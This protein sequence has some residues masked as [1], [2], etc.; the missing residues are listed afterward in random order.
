M[1][2]KEKE[3]LN[4]ITQTIQK[5]KDVSSIQQIVDTQSTVNNTE[6][7]SNSMSEYER[8]QKEAQTKAQKQ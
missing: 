7:V 1:G 4:R 6:T 5:R 2:E 8:L 3:L